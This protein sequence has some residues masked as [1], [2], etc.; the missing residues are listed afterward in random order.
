MVQIQEGAAA[1]FYGSSTNPFPVH[2]ARGGSF[3]SIPMPSKKKKLE[4]KEFEPRKM[5][6]SKKN[7]QEDKI[8]KEFEPRKMFES[9]RNTQE[10][11]IHLK[12]SKKVTFPSFARK[13][14]LFPEK[15]TKGS[16]HP[17]FCIRAMLND[18][19]KIE[20]YGE[21]H[22]IHEYLLN[23]DHLNL[24]PAVD[25]A[26]D[27]SAFKKKHFLENC[28]SEDENDY[29]DLIR[30]DFTEE[31]KSQI[32]EFE[33]KI[34]GTDV[35]VCLDDFKSD[36][37][38]VNILRMQLKNELDI[39]NQMDI[40]CL[41]TRL[42]EMLFDRSSNE[43]NDQLE[44]KEDLLELLNSNL[45]GDEKSRKKLKEEID[46]LKEALNILEEELEIQ[47][48]N[49]FNGILQKNDKSTSS[50]SER[51][52]SSK[53]LEEICSKKDLEKIRDLE[54]KDVY[55]FSNK[56]LYTPTAE[57]LVSLQDL[58]PLIETLTSKGNIKKIPPRVQEI[59]YEGNCISFIEKNR[60]LDEFTTVKEDRP[61]GKDDKII[62]RLN[63][64]I[65]TAKELL[66]MICKSF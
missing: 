31:F 36:D 13:T 59:I 32:A 42:I 3:K 11:K 40:R 4:P 8:P 44:I 33:K 23:F 18:I 12:G 49:P 29:V 64:S 22:E 1:T 50:F 10:D 20:H 43:K 19:K 46:K 2:V 48:K 56:R 9:K 55:S 14:E 17:R 63:A 25:N 47:K 54:K 41:K 53:K 24:D 60:H 30:E 34:T 27:L 28:V 16:R 57:D 66:W 51:Y 62:I 7:T 38:D 61:F 58:L 35:F 45:F 21:S 15:L 6:E 65:I 26:I 37:I 39:H 5:F 52:V